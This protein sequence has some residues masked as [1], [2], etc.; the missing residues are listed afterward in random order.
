[1]NNTFTPG[2]WKIIHVTNR[3]IGKDL[4]LDTI[5]P[6][7]ICGS[8]D[9]QIARIDDEFTNNLTPTISALA[10]AHLIAAAPDLFDVLQKIANWELPDTG[11]FWDNENTQPMSYEACN[12]TN[13]SRDY[14]KSLAQKAINKALN[15]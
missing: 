14:F 3:E 2:P 7:L 11:K 12:G 13:G 5:A 10:N 4:G 9:V 15:K 6:Y 1:M 8:D